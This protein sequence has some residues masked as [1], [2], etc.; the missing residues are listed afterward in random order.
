MKRLL[1]FK[2]RET[3]EREIFH[4]KIMSDKLLFNTDKLHSTV[5]SQCEGVGVRV[6]KNKKIGFASSTI[7]TDE[8]IE[9]ALE[10]AEYGSVA[11]FSFASESQSF[12]GE[13]YIDE[14]IKNI[15][16]DCLI[17]KGNSIIREIKSFNKNI[18][19]NLTFNK[20]QQDINLVTSRGFSGSY[21]QYIYKVEIAT[22]ITRK[23]DIFVIE[24]TCSNEKEDRLVKELLVD[25]DKGINTETIET[26]KYTLLFS[27]YVAEYMLETFIRGI[28][29][30]VI[31][32]NISPMGSKLNEQ[33]FN[34]RINIYDDGTH[35]GRTGHIPF[36]DEG[37]RSQKTMLV[38]KG[39]LKNFLLDL[40][41]AG[42]L[43]MAPTGNGLRT[44]AEEIRGYENP[45]HPA[46]R[47]VIMEPG[48]MESETILSNIES[49]LFIKDTTN[50]HG[51]R[52]SGDL[53][54]LILLGYK[55]KNGKITGRIKNANFTGNLYN[56]LSNNLLEIS[57]DTIYSG[58]YKVPWLLF[59]DIDITC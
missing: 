13:D 43:N 12:S 46:L 34:N 38:E 15:N 3:D 8:V 51:G 22:E 52:I 47:T 32:R 2:A 10:N 56:L 26:G 25:I 53:S 50:L 23:N 30:N 37:V 39:I 58:S 16:T 33:I 14:Y 40:R 5:R 48:H 41:T 29:G 11:D 18:S 6:K 35:M 24:R 49:G 1:E 42:K 28:Y 7:F 17:D 31:T 27:P 57:S 55:I 21:R 45:P 36:D 44:F 9:K 20:K 54:G 19:V 59:R 4:M